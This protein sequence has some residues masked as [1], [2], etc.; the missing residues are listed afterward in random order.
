MA[1]RILVMTAISSGLLSAAVNDAIFEE[2][3]R[4]ILA[5][6]CQS[7]HS[8]KTKSSGFSVANVEGVL[9]GGSK[10]GPAVIPGDAANSPLVKILKGHLSPRMPL[11]AALA[12]ADIA[13]I[14]QWIGHLKPAATTAGNIDW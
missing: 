11:G 7:C 4:P 6:N 2:K 5:A 9:A 14:E 8:A 3:I 12:N 13:T 10:N 1:L